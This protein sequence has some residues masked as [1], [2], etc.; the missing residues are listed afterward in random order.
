MT[1][2]NPLFNDNRLKLGIFGFNG[3]APSNT[4][5][6][7]LYVPSWP[8]ILDI[9]AI[10]DTAGFEAVVPFARWKH[11][12]SRDVVNPAAME[13]YD[14]FVWAAGIAQATTHPAV[15]ATSHMSLVHPLIAAKQG[16]TIDHISHGR[17]AL[18]VVAGWNEPEFQMFGGTLEEHTDRYAQASEWMDVLR[19]LWQEDDEFDFDGRYFSIKK[20]ESFPKPRQQPMPP[21]MSAGGSDQGRRFAARYADMCF[22][23]IRSDQPEG[24]KADVDAYR[25]LAKREF[26]RDIQVWTV[27]YVIQRDTQQAAEAYQRRVL[28]HADHRA[29]DSMLA[30]LGSQSKMMSKEAFEAFSNRYIAG[31]GGFPL[32]GSADVIVDRCTR[33]S[34]A[35]V[36]GV[37][38]CWID[39][40]DGL[41]RWNRD[42]MPMLEQSGLRKPA[43]K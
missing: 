26:G 29:N 39:Y 12:R 5:L 31:A 36:D 34:R 35:G 24:A 38:L 13:V 43:I 37:L 15:M 3:Q 32:V 41:T 33:L 11:G 6:E 1:T 30:M 7:E 19:R 4:I 23:L 42:V 2:V 18:N 14:P 17:F 8:R 9:A 16:A 40:V 20:G 10:A 25:D 28:D 27:A 21:I 22:T